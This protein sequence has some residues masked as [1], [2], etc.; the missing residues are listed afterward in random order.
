MSDGARR[1]VKFLAPDAK[2]IEE[3]AFDDVA[4]RFRR[5]GERGARLDHPHLIKIFSYCE[6]EDG[7]AF[8]HREPKN[9]FIVMEQVQGRTLENHIRK[10]RSTTKQFTISQE[11]LHIGIQ[12]AN[13]LYELHRMKLIHRDVKPANVFIS[14]RSSEGLLPLVKLGDFGIV[15]WGDFQ[16]SVSTGV[17]TVTNQKG[18]GTLKYMSPEQ[19][20]SPR[21]IT[22]RSDIYPLGITLFELFT[23]QI[24]S[25]PHHVYEIMGARLNRGNTVSR[26]LLM[27]YHIR[28]EDEH[29][30]GLL[31]DMHRRGPTGRP[32][33]DNVR[34]HLESEYERRYE[35]DWQADLDNSSEG[36]TDSWDD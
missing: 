11:T 25:S 31:L 32:S 21:D 20:I 8:E 27:G 30:A 3:S 2:Y 1:A 7:S 9:P 19:A 36:F 5:E 23:G 4:T 17:L 33:I 28:P 34:G 16:A 12:V 35:N 29:L 26:Y 15:K 22:V 6:N 24:L 14:K 18:L 13:A 10:F